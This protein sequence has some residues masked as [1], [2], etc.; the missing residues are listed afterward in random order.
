VELR[1][2]RR[3]RP[4][5]E[6]R[7][8]E[9][10]RRL[11]PAW[12]QGAEVIGMEDRLPPGE[13]GPPLRGDVVAEPARGRSEPRSVVVDRP[14]ELVAD[15]EEPGRFRPRCRPRGNI[16]AEQGTRRARGDPAQDGRHSCSTSAYRSE[17]SA[18]RGTRI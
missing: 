4:S 8:P 5:V 2:A 12:P 1:I 17:M 14:A 9:P 18:S 7:E 16:G 15:D 13:A 6:I 3:A 11:E 10:V